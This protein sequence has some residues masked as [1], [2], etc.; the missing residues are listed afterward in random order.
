MAIYTI[1]RLSIQ[2]HGHTQAFRFMIALQFAGPPL[3]T[4]NFWCV[5]L[6]LLILI[7]C[8]V[9]AVDEAFFEPS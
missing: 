4:G 7:L 3:I 2:S 8:P 5:D 1:S 6:M 9:T